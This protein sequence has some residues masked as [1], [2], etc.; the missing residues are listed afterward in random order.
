MLKPDWDANKGELW[1]LVVIKDYIGTFCW[2]VLG[3]ALTVS[4]TFNSILGIES[5][6]TSPDYREKLAD[7]A[8]AALKKK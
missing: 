7:K 3:M 2:L 1:N 5:C 8:N 6:T 4:T